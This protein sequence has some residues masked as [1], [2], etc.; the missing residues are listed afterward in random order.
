MG[1]LF[2]EGTV[3]YVCLGRSRFSFATEETSAREV[4]WTNCLFPTKIP[5]VSAFTVTKKIV[6]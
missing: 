6:A 3:M 2:P 4:L 1:V 5:T